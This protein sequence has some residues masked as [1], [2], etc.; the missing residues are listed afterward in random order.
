[1]EN[2]YYIAT[3]VFLF[4]LILIREYFSYS[5]FKRLNLENKI[6]HAICSSLLERLEKGDNNA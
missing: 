4:G 6:L 2:I 3:I 5:N 1:M